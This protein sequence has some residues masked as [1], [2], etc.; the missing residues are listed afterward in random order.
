MILLSYMRVTAL[1]NILAYKSK[2]E[3]LIRSYKQIA[4][5]T[6]DV[7]ISGRRIR[8]ESHSPVNSASALH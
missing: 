3:I 7:S 4:T 6:Q 5:I 2:R 1:Q 8:R